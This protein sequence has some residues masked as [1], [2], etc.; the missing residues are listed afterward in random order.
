MT[1][2][3]T[4]IS[5]ALRNVLRNRQKIVTSVL[6]V[7]LAVTLIFG[8][9]L[10]LEMQSGAVLQHELDSQSYHFTIAG[11]T[12]NL[13]GIA[14]FN[15][16]HTKIS[17]VEGI[18]KYHMNVE[19]G[20]QF[21]QTEM[22]VYLNDYNSSNES[23]SDSRGIY[24]NMPWYQY[25]S[26][27][28]KG[29]IF[30]PEFMGNLYGISVGDRVN[31]TFSGIEHRWD[32]NGTE[33]IIRDT[34][35]TRT[36]TVQA[37][38]STGDRYADESWDYYSIWYR[39]VIYFNGDDYVQI[40]KGIAG[41][42]AED[43]PGTSPGMYLRFEY[44]GKLDPSIYRKTS[45]I[46]AENRAEKVEN[47][48]WLVENDIER[49]H[50]ISVWVEAEYQE[51]F[52]DSD[53]YF[54]EI[55]YILIALSI[56]IIIFGIYLGY[57]GIDLFLSE[58]RREIGML[59]ARGATNGQLLI[60]LIS[61]ALFVG[62]FAGI[63]GIILAG[64]GSKAI[65]HFTSASS[66]VGIPWYDPGFS[67]NALIS[68][69]LLGMLL[70]FGSSFHLL[71]RITKLE[72]G[73]LLSKYSRRQEKP[74]NATRDAKLM[75]FAVFCLFAIKFFTQ[76][77]EI[78]HSV[79]N[80]IISM[81]LGIFTYMIVPVMVISAPYIIIIVGVR[82]ATRGS[83]RL[84][85]KLA[86]IAE[87]ITGELGYLIRRNIATGSRR[88]VNLTTVLSVL[89]AFLVLTSVFTF[90]QKD[91][92]ERTLRTEIGSDMKVRMSY[93]PSEEQ[94]HSMIE[95]ITGIPGVNRAIPI[96]GTEA[97][98][99]SQGNSYLKVFVVNCS[100]YSTISYF[101]KDLFQQGERD[102]VR[103]L[104]SGGVIVSSHIADS[105]GLSMDEEIHLYEEKWD[106]D[107]WFS[108]TIGLGSYNIKGEMKSLPGLH[109]SE[110][111]DIKSRWILM[112]HRTFNGM[113]TESDAENLSVMQN[114]R[115]EYILISTS[116]SAD[117][118]DI[119]ASIME[120]YGDDIRNIRI[121][122]KELR[123]LNEEPNTD[124]FLLVLR[125]QLGVVVFIS[126]LA[127]ATVVFISSYEKRKERAA[128][129]LKGTTSRQLYQLEFG[130]AL[131]ILIYALVVGL[132][133]G[134]IGGI[135]WIFVFNV[136]EDL[137]VIDRSYWPSLSILPIIGLM[138]IIFLLAVTISTYKL[139]R[140]D[141][142]KLMRWG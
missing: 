10:S 125:T 39:P 38:W 44:Y 22:G 127:S 42:M 32:E 41:R 101:D 58:R 87:L 80:I 24:G 36:Y 46:K 34:Y 142:I 45:L 82:L 109:K 108:R 25:P 106:E 65:L 70:M 130:E 102:D 64:Y 83:T 51:A 48:L 133:T 37:L 56:P 63:I 15:E 112:D 67:L 81:V 66:Y 68:A 104:S 135:V 131:V 60:L 11:N 100:V 78:E 1:V 121:A 54:R 105:D 140:F 35:L 123:E 86:E 62:A 21:H 23:S 59:K 99:R 29:K 95:N 141:L 129:M 4:F 69:V 19:A 134:I 40:M 113:I 107:E 50:P 2:S 119:S 93:T 73:E 76:L 116:S 61:E 16:T 77:D 111:Q 96:Y 33:V 55:V 57:L 8:E 139:R 132:I 120:M 30:L 115:A 92:E 91:L 3:L 110:I 90:A 128:I 26:A 14:E 18:E 122:S 43:D 12:N 31:L 6:G 124:S 27:P 98:F 89:F 94:M 126:L 114:R 72:A 9:T 137:Q 20:L 88:I 84:F 118:D 7:I 28:D 52:R 17:S 97:Q 74:Y 13:T 103:A 138:V 136:F 47:D 85:T 5:M 49:T 71:R 79:D 75:G 53:N 117:G